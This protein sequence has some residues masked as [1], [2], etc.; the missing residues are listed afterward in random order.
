[1]AQHGAGKV[2]ALNDVF[3]ELQSHMRPLQ[4][5]FGVFQGADRILRK[6]DGFLRMMQK[7]SSIFH[8][9]AGVALVCC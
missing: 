9:L 4:G 7:V 8:Q 1:M 2:K 6:G 5:E 3:H